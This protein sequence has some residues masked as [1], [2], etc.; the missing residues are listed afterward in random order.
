M[1]NR[2]TS[3]CLSHSLPEGFFSG[4]YPHMML[5]RLFSFKHFSAS[6]AGKL[7]RLM[8][9][10]HMCLQSAFQAKFLSTNLALE[11]G[12]V[13]VSRIH[14]ISQRDGPIKHLAAIFA[15]RIVF[16]PLMHVG[17]VI[18]QAALQEALAAKWTTFS[19]TVVIMMSLLV[20][21]Q[22]HLEECGIATYLTGKFYSLIMLLNLVSLPRS[23]SLENEFTVVTLV[24]DGLRVEFSLLLDAILHM[25]WIFF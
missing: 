14:M 6:F 12:H 1:K 17:D 3:E 5:Q 15:L 18:F 21:F 19:P 7:R 11:V 9:G 22:V 10:H 2:S 23:I 8:R 24:N 25:I 16:L 13:S 4:M 20:K